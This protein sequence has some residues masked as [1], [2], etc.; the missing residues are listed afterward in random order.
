MFEKI[1]VAL[2]LRTNGIRNQYVLNFEQFCLKELE[3][4]VFK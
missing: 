4:P 3:I 2:D 1:R